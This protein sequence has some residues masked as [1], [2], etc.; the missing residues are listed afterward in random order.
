MLQPQKLTQMNLVLRKPVFMQ[1]F[2]LADNQTSQLSYISFQDALNFRMS[3]HN[4]GSDQ[5]GQS[6][7]VVFLHEVSTLYTWRLPLVQITETTQNYRQIHVFF[8]ICFHLFLT[9]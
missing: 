8:P 3:P 1:G 4:S 7:K 2:R 6:Q 9:F 5:T